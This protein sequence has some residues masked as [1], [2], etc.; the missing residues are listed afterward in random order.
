[1]KPVK[2]NFIKLIKKSNLIKMYRDK[3]SVVKSIFKPKDS[4]TKI[5][6][7]EH[8]EA[9]INQEKPIKPLKALKDELF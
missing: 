9:V 2:T 5:T 3:I 4:Q 6:L 1:M 8:K 7:Q